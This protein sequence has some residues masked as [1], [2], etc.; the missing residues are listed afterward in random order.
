AIQR[1]TQARAAAVRMLID[2][3]SPRRAVLLAGHAETVRVLFNALRSEPGVVAI[4]GARVHAAA[5]RWSRDE[6]LRALGPRNAPW[7]PDDLRGIRLLLATDILAEGVELQG[8]A[9]VIHG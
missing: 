8:C 5:G 9:T 4:V 6:V 2:S 3:E 1:D 7:R